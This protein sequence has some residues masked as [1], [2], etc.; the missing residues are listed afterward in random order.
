MQGKGRKLLLLGILWRLF[1]EKSKKVAIK[2]GRMK[3]N[4]YFCR[5]KVIKRNEND[6][7]CK[8]LVVAQLKIRKIVRR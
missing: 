1:R 3:G 6:K 2:F 8:L 5:Q 7:N 4:V